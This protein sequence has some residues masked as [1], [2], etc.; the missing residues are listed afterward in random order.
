MP[1]QTDPKK[2]K[3][4]KG[5]GDTMADAANGPTPP[6]P[7]LDLAIFTSYLSKEGLVKLRNLHLANQDLERKLLDYQ[8][9]HR[10]N[11]DDINQRTAGW[12]RERTELQKQND[13]SNEECLRLQGLL[14]QADEAS[15]AAEQAAADL[16]RQLQQSQATNAHHLEACRSKDNQITML[17]AR[18]GTAHQQATE[19]TEKSK[20]L[21]DELRLLKEQQE[22]LS[23][24]IATAQASLATVRDFMVNL[25]PLDQQQSLMLVRQSQPFRTF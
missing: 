17:E 20:L 18:I 8:A 4:R 12:E 11:V 3:G 13:H 15:E 21:S 6:D 14:I 25:K 19:A 7:E 22:V 2:V 24:E 23:G 1:S 5:S 16:Q 9:A 10:V